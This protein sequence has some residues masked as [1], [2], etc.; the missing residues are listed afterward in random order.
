[1]MASDDLPR[2]ERRLFD[3]PRRIARIG[4]GSLGGKALGLVAAARV[5][6]EQREAIATAGLDVDVPALVVVA[7]SVFESFLD[8]NGLRP[9]LA[10]EPPDAEIALAFQRATLPTEWLGD[11]RSLAEE[12]RV[13][14]ACRS[15]SA[16]EDAL[17]RPF[18]GVYETKMIPGN[19]PDVAAR[20]KSLVDAI[21][22]VYAS[23]FLQAARDYRRGAGPLPAAEAMAVVIQE[24][25]GR[26]HGE[27]FYPDISGVA[28]SYSFYPVGPA[29]PE[30]GVVDLA[31]GLGKTIVDGGLCWTFSPAHPRIGPPVGSV[32]QRID[33]T[34]SQLWAVNV[35]PPPPYDPMAETEYLVQASLAD[36][37]ADGT[38]R[39]TASTYDADSDRLVPG[40]GRSGP[41]VLDF[42]PILSWDEL[43]LVPA[44]RKLMAAC[45]NAL[46]A[47][48]EIEFALSLP[49][50][51]PARF[52]FLQVRPL[53]VS[54]EAVSVGEDLLTG[55]RAVVASTTALGNGRQQLQDVVY[56][57]P[58]GFEARLTPAIAL[59]IESLNRALVETGRPYLLIGFGRW[60]SS[61]PWLGVPVRWDQIA[62]ARAIV[63]ATLP[64]L[65]PDPSQGSH[66]F[67]N[68]S[69]FS[70]LYFTVPH[71]R[72]RGID[73]AWLEAQEAVARTDHV[74]HVRVAR[75]LVV[76]VDGRTRRGVVLRPA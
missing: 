21:K 73:W 35:G 66:F 39:H 40:T 13:P 70:V 38:L 33:T 37:E 6:E 9:L 49:P 67:H 22:F 7:T 3:P 56:V 25:V 26:R 11:L 14:L 75:P 59:E 18:A 44:V 5:L 36:A 1:V 60:G 10:E 12:A 32:R 42:A 65:S 58:A 28:R 68:L 53:L 45:E 19:Q 23:T 50:G 20:F 24:V 52:G 63:E 48:V 61:D 17:G 27:R 31:V 8:R 72:G 54:H 2:F 34:Q 43:P 47:P 76:E 46:G 55:P 16:L 41:R 74:R 64:Q 57:D 4:D 62:G 71:G 29:T 51:R 15:S 30:Q 69:S